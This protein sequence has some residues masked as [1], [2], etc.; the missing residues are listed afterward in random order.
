MVAII[1]PVGQYRETYLKKTLY[2]YTGAPHTLEKLLA[3]LPAAYAV[4][5]K[6]H[7]YALL[8][9]GH[10]QITKTPAELIILENIE[11]QMYM[12]FGR[13]NDIK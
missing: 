5:Y 9:L 12:L 2:I 1:E 11:L 10:E 13:R 4:I 6:T 8:G 7:L 3:H